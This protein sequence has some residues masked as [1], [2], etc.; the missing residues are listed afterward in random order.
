ME[1]VEESNIFFFVKADQ[2]GADR[3]S[4]FYQGVPGRRRANQSQEVWN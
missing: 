1:T 4:P 3:S 2:H